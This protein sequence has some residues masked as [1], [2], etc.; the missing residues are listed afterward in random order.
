V[1]ELALIRI[2]GERIPV[3]LD[4]RPPWQADTAA[5]LD[6]EDKTPPC[7][8]NPEKNTEVT[9]TVPSGTYRGVS[10][11]NGVPEKVNHAD[12]ATWPDP[13]KTYQ[14]DLY[15]P[16]LLGFRFIKA[17]ATEVTT[18]TGFGAFDLAS[19]ECSGDPVI[20]QKRNYNI[21]EIDH[22]DVCKDVVLVDFGQIFQK[23]DLAQPTECPAIGPQCPDFF[24]Q[25][26]VDYD[27]GQAVLGQTVYRKR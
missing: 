20:C 16:D 15:W 11:S 4:V 23:A 10:F 24:D 7:I 2:D 1:Q 12:P 6:F 25:V 5:L 19:T 18:H 17:R 22:F 26:G 9:G 14:G 21:V 8:G 13:Y 27:T 3:K